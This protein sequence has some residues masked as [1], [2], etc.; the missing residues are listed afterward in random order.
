MSE[1]ADTVAALKLSVTSVFVPWSQSRNRDEKDDRGNPRLSLNWRV[2][3]QRDGRD[4]L[5]TDYSAG[6]GHCPS[7]AR[8]KRPHSPTVAEWH[9]IERECETGRTSAL[10]ATRDRV[11]GSAIKPNP[12]DV[13]YSLALDASVTDEGTFENWAASLGYDPDSR[14]AEAIWRA[15]LDLALRLRAALGDEGLAALREAFADY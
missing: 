10:G 15:C 14:K 2:T 8:L 13:L 1:P 4:V 6:I 11:N 9:D 5:T 12:L 3:L 7:Y